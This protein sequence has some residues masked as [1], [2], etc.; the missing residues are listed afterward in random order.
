[1]ESDTNYAQQGR[2]NSLRK[3][4]F[5]PLTSETNDHSTKIIPVE[6]TQSVVSTGNKNAFQTVL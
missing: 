6:T 3:V 1:M 2:I 4:T 5:I